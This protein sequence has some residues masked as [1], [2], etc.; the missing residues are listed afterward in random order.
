LLKKIWVITMFPEMFGAFL[1]YGVV[2]SSLRGERGD[3]PELRLV[4]ISDYTEK[5]FK[6]IDSSPYGGGAGMVMRADVMEKALLEG[7]FSQYQ[8][9]D[10][11]LIVVA[12][13]PRGDR[14]DQSSA[15]ELSCE[16]RDIVFVCGRYEGIDERFLDKYVHR[17]LSLGDFILSGGELACMSY[18]DA[19]VRLLKG[20]VANENSIVE[21]SFEND[22]LEYPHYT[23]PADC[24]DQEVPKVLR[25]GDH[26]AIKKW[27]DTKQQE[28]TMKYRPDLLKDIK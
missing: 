7:I 15:R 16:K 17:H 12:T 9:P 1:D 22:L 10:K 8:E 20:A 13:G 24:C 19:T 2:G 3:M 14:F 25:S 18:I 21:E 5:G 26:K 27:R 11:E 23:R 4:K 6:G 28:M